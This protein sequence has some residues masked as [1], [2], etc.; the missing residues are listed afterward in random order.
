MLKIGDTVRLKS[1]GPQ[2]TVNSIEDN[3]IKCQWFDG[4]NLK[5]G[6][7]HKDQLEVEPDEPYV[8]GFND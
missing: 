6:V 2:M 4:N 8:G 7:F 1:G 5:E 3:V